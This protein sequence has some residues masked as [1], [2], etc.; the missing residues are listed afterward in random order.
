MQMQAA[1]RPPGVRVPPAQ[2]AWCEVSHGLLTAEL[3]RSSSDEAVHPGVEPASLMDAR[4]DW[5]Q[6]LLEVTCRELAA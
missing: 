3:E 4:I 5:C 6:L 2:L 1:G